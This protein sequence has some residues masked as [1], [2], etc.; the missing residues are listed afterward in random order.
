MTKKELLA[1]LTSFPTSLTIS[2]GLQ[3]QPQPK[4]QN[5]EI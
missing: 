2:R 4:V 1:I 3:T 5:D